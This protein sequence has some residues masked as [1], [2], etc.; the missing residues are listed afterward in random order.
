MAIAVIYRWRIL[1]GREAEFAAA[2]RIVTDAIVAACGS[3][4][5]CLHQ[6]S[7]GIFVAYARWQSEAARQACFANQLTAASTS[8]DVTAARARMRAAIAEALPEQ[9]LNVYD[10]ALSFSRS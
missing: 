5:S 7:E 10:D 3:H 1:P 8:A 2:W 4:G 6:D 9:V